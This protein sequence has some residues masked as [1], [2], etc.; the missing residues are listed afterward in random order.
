MTILAAEL[1]LI[2]PK[3][4]KLEFEDFLANTLEKYKIISNVEDAY[5]TR[6]NRVYPWNRRI[7]MFNGKLVG[8]MEKFVELDNIF[9]FAFLHFR[10]P[11]VIMLYQKEQHFDYDFTF[12]FDGEYPYGFRVCYGLDIEKPFL[13]FSK[14]KDEFVEGARKFAQIKEHMVED[15]VYTL[16]PTRSNTVLQINGVNYPHRV[17]LNSSTNRLVFIVYGKLINT[18]QMP[19]LHII[20]E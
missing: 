10:D 18:E 6:N 20:K 19:Y 14:L 4:P 16:S 1:D 11:T 15:K 7:L 9:T 3:E 5:F 17:P 12:H 2:V 8:G 13:E